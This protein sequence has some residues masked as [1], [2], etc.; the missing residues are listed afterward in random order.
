MCMARR[1]PRRCARSRTC[2]RIRRRKSSLLDHVLQLQSVAHGFN[3]TYSTP[4]SPV[5]EEAPRAPSPKGARADGSAVRHEAVTRLLAA[6]ALKKAPAQSRSRRSSLPSQTL[7]LACSAKH[8]H[9]QDDHLAAPC[10]G[11]TAKRHSMTAPGLPGQH[12][13]SRAATSAATEDRRCRAEEKSFQDFWQV[14][15]A[16]NIALLML[17][18]LLAQLLMMEIFTRSSRQVIQYL[19]RTRAQLTEAPMVASGE[20]HNFEKRRQRLSHVRRLSSKQSSFVTRKTE[21]QELDALSELSSMQDSNLTDRSSACTCLQYVELLARERARTRCSRP[22]A[23]T[24]TGLHMYMTCTYPS[25]C[26]HANAGGVI[27]HTHTL[28]NAVILSVTSH[29]VRFD[30]TVALPSGFACV[31]QSGRYS[32][33]REHALHVI[34]QTFHTHTH[35]QTQCQSFCEAKSA[36]VRTTERTTGLEDVVGR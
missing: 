35:T 16:T 17:S 31:N 3:R 34:T 13:F 30:S 23:D 26:A 8:A 7:P 33:E 27:P 28:C 19:T 2:A 6:H 14:C 32:S 12:A 22:S 10:V 18:P 20:N 15:S 1:P 4:S 9:R 36:G 11:R 29:R 5:A 25:T 24:H 21:K